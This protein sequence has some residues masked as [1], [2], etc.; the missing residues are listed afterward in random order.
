METGQNSVGWGAFLRI[1][2]G[3]LV[4]QVVQIFA[5]QSEMFPLL[6]LPLAT[7]ILTL[8]NLQLASTVCRLSYSV[9]M[10]VGGLNNFLMEYVEK[11]NGL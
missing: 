3:P 4:L 6:S 7:A 9:H 10:Y 1:L 5:E 8:I 11:A 2:S